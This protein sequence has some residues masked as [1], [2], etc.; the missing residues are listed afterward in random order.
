MMMMMILIIV[1][2]EIIFF[3]SLLG[4]QSKVRKSKECRTVTPAHQT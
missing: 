3:C 2:L 1:R 4:C